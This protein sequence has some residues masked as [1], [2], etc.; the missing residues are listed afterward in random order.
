MLNKINLENFKSFKTLTD[1]ELKPITII[2]GTNSCGKSSILQSILTMKQT[3]RSQKDNQT[4]LLNGKYVHLG[5]YKNLVYEKKNNNYIT[6]SFS[7]LFNKNN[8]KFEYKHFLK[9]IASAHPENDIDL[10]N[11]LFSFKI[12][13][14][15]INKKGKINF[16]KPILVHEYSVE[17]DFKS[18]T[19]KELNYKT[20]I[21]FILNQGETYFIN[22]N[23]LSLL[24]FSEED[25][26]VTGE[27]KAICEFD[28]LIPRIKHIVRGQDSNITQILMFF[29]R[30]KD[31]MTNIFNSYSYIGPL[32]EEAARRYIYE[33]EVTEIGLKG[34][35]A[36]YLYMTQGNNLLEKVFFYDEENK[37]FSYKKI[38]LKD[39]VNEWLKILG[40]K[41]FDSSL[42]NDIIHLNLKANPH[43]EIDI[44]IA[45]VGFGI[46]QVF[47]IILEGLRINTN[48]TLI[49]EQPEIHLHPK[50][51]MDLADYFLSLAKAKKNLLIETH[52]EHL[53]NRLVRRIIE[54]ETN[55]IGKL[56]KI[57][58][59]SA[60]KDGAIYEEIKINNNQGIINW[61]DDFFDQNAI[62]Q[63]KIILAGILKRKKEREN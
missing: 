24:G 6:L 33:N 37:E 2:C 9:S 20:N 34:E 53:I 8:T 49:L 28:N 3:F 57:Y 59:I 46:S 42:S 16:I 39:A 60:T 14:K 7:F 40:I 54:D 5:S 13:F 51:Q 11:I 32:R 35:N 1:L 19:K 62:E 45:D 12:K 56:I 52:S 25:F 17:I 4:L 55:T 22:W 26:K 15:S 38:K 61:P 29:W 27:T 58:F 21:S 50:M 31:F 43:S 63:E 23:N 44:N 47:P 30:Y 10:N 18:K 48:D 36:P 41:G